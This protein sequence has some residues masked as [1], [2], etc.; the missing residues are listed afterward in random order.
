MGTVQRAGSPD[1][2]GALHQRDAAQGYLLPAPHGADRGDPPYH[3][4][5]GIGIECNTNRGNTPL[6]DADILKLYRS[7]GGEIITLGSDAHVTNHLGCA[8]PARQELLRDCGFRY[9]TT[10]DRM[11]PSF[12]AL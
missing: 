7:L 6:P 10:F 4:S 5:K 8:I 11:K 3:H 12:Q 9:F 1:A 2:A